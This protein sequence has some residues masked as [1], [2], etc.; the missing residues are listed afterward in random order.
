V[1]IKQYYYTQM[2][3]SITVVEYGIYIISNAMTV[4]DPS[5]MHAV[6]QSL[7]TLGPGVTRRSYNDAHMR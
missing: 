2:T 5:N 4:N 1:V 6:G 3:M 7:G